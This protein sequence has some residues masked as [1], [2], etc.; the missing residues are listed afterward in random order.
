MSECTLCGGRGT[1]EIGCSVCGGT[2][3]LEKETLGDSAMPIKFREM[4]GHC[5]GSGVVVRYPC[6]SCRGKVFIG[7]PEED[8]DD[9]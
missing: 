2:G 5:W 3:Y 4:C 9:R 1:I 8:E 7:G 6:W